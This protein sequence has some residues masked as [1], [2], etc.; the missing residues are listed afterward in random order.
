MGAPGENREFSGGK[1][2]PGATI[3][4]T[5]L[6]LRFA[7]RPEPNPAA[8]SAVW[9]HRDE[10]PGFPQQA[11][12]SVH[13]GSAAAGARLPLVGTV[14]GDHRAGDVDEDGRRVAARVAP[15]DRHGLAAR[16]A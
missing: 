7:T 3:I 4:C 5:G 9:K 14:D 11:E 16:S 1:G 6:L 8:P 15:A 13:D 10:L 2:Y 12:A